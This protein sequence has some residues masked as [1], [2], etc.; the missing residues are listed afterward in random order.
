MAITLDQVKEFLRM[1]HDEEDSLLSSYLV[2]SERY[3]VNATH[4]N[5]DKR[6]ELF[7]IAQRFLIAHWYEN[8]NTVLVGQTSKS[9]EFALE[10]ILT[11]LKYTSSDAL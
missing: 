7:G 5:V 10:S 2:A 6:D 11:Q 4:T 9:L 8:R 3:I 1:D